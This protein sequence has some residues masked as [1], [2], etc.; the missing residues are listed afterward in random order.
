MLT[1]KTVE[2]CG[3]FDERFW[4]AYYEDTDYVRRLELTGCH[5]AANP[6]PKIAVPGVCPQARSLQL[7]LAQPDMDKLRDR[8]VRKWGGVYPDYVFEYPWNDPS[9]D[10]RDWDRD[11]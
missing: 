1:A 9:I 7:G 11:G 10:V 3:L 2:A 4:P 5:S 8:H 6:M